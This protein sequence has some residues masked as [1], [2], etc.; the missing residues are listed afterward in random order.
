MFRICRFLGIVVIALLLFLLK[1]VSS[2]G[3]FRIRF[4][5]PIF[6]TILSCVGYSEQLLLPRGEI[7]S[8]AIKRRSR[9]KARKQAYN[10]FSAPNVSPF[11]F[12]F[13]PAVGLIF[14]TFERWHP[15][16]FLIHN[17]AATTQ[18]QGV[19]SQKQAGKHARHRLHFI[20]E[21]ENKHILLYFP[22]RC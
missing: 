10:I 20:C 7:T 8:M 4:L 9:F 17:S 5:L 19:V 12:A 2:G 15:R 11:S 13:P 21:I 18:Q 14:R 3:T 16:Y 22:T 1:V 6:R